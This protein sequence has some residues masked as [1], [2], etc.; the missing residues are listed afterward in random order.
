MA[1]GAARRYGGLKQLAPVGPSGEAI[2]EYSIH[3]ALA[4]GFSKVVLVVRPEYE[5]AFREKFVNRASDRVEI[6]FA[7]QELETELPAKWRSCEREKPW[8]TAHAVLCASGVI[9]GPFAVINADDFYGPTALAQMGSFLA[10]VTAK[11]PMTGAMI[12]YELRNTL[13][14]H[15][16][17]SRGVCET[18]TDGM[19]THIVERHSIARRGDGGE[20]QPPNGAAQF[21][22]G[23]TPVSMNLWGYPA[24]MFAHLRERFSQFL[25]G[26]REASQ[27][28]EIPTV[29]KRL[30]DE[31]LMRVRVFKTSERW[32]GMTYQEDLPVVQER[33]ASLVEE[34]VYPE[35]LW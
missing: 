8:G 16:T 30:M 23:D 28:F 24:L 22:P 3:D 20:F 10:G 27:E 17:V 33:I 21:L 35:R 31:G 15:G 9:D 5:E 13:S 2:M 25:D 11:T 32:S 1:A 6:A 34:G 4:G 7:Y 29:T 19:L 26:P 12:G 14:D 18:D